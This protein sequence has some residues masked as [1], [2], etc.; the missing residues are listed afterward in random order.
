MD[1]QRGLRVLCTIGNLGAEEMIS[2]L[3]TLRYIFDI[4]RC[5][6]YAHTTVDCPKNPYNSTTH[7]THDEILRERVPPCP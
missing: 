4:P 2:R 6:S 5:V 7:T 3:L 1:Q